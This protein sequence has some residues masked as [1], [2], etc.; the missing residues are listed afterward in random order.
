LGDFLPMTAERGYNL[1]I[2]LS[3]IDIDIPIVFADR[4]I[5]A[6]SLDKWT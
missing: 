5:V 1:T 2:P 4:G 6:T 3:N